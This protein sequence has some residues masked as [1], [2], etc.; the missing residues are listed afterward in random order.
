MSKLDRPWGPGRQRRVAE[1]N[2]IVNWMVIHSQHDESLQRRIGK[3]SSE[4]IRT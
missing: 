4:H 2:V 1:A 3:T